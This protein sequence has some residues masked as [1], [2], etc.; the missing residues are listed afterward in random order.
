MGDFF[1]MRRLEGLMC[2]DV[3]GEIEIARRL[4]DFFA[5]YWMDGVCKT[6]QSMTGGKSLGFHIMVE[7]AKRR[8]G[9]CK[10]PK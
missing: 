10:A 1:G 5:S 8:H 7:R 9:L 4:T 3:V 2:F 6:L